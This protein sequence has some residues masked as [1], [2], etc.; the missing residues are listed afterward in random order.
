MIHGRAGIRCDQDIGRQAFESLLYRRVLIG[1]SGED[2]DDPRDG[3]PVS[4][5]LFFV[6]L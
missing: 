2:G 3:Y 6:H 1:V 5:L 4:K